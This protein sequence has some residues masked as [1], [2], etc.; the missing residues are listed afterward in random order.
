VG[1]RALR[2]VEAPAQEL[3]M[4]KRRQSLFALSSNCGSA[5]SFT[6]SV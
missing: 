2:H 3:F 1:A 6:T 4:I 5:V